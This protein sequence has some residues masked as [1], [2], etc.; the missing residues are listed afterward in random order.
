MPDL[1]PFV[2]EKKQM[3]KQLSAL[4]VGLGLAVGASAQP[5]STTP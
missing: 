2:P 3:F 1:A 4:I 5:E